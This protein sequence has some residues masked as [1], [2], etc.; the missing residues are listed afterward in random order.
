M[1]VLAGPTA[2]GKSALA[3]AL[4][5]RIGAEIVSCDSAQVYR[6][7]D[8]GSAKVRP[9]EQQGVPHHLIDVV[10]P[11]QR[12]TVADYQAQALAAIESIHRRGRL[13]LLVGGTGLWLR[14]VVR[15]YAFPAED[16]D[17][18]LRRQIAEAAGQYGWEAIRRALRMV[19]PESY[20]K[21]SAGDRR[22]LARALEVWW[23]TGQ[24]MVRNA[25]P[26]PYRVSY[27]VV[28]RPV[29]ELHRRIAQRTEAMLT[30]GLVEEVEDLLRRGVAPRA[31]SLSAIGYREAVD[32]C[33]GRLTLGELERLIRRHSEQLAKRQMT[34]FRGEDDV[35][36]LDLA[37]WGE[38]RALDT[39]V[40]A[41]QGLVGQSVRTPG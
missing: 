36:W 17:A 28:F 4:A 21:I 5:R 2:V 34:W 23:N 20:Q 32:W 12:F 8:I 7:L 13:P 29:A 10:D 40:K 33:F 31:Q 16:Q 18:P 26:S 14:A 35:H 41:A 22:R 37:A 24:P 1:L 6:G 19:D 25:G 30:E 15:D 9:R 3:I 27:W 38:E 11:D 39:L